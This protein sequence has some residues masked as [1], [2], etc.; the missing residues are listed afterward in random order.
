MRKIWDIPGGIHPPENK[1]QSLRSAIAAVPLPERLILPLN[2][3]A[4]APAKP[5]ISVGDRVLKGQLLAE[6]AGFISAAIHAPTSGTISAIEDHPIPHASGMSATCIML[7][8]DGRDDWCA[9]H[10]VEDYTTASPTALLGLIRDAGITGLGGAG[11]P[12]AVKLGPKQPIDTLIINGTECEPYITADDILMQERAEQII[13]GVKIIA[14]ILGNPANLLIGVEDNKPKAFDALEAAARNSGIEVIE[15]PTK[16]PSGGEKQLIQILTGKEVPSGRLPADLGIVCQNVGTTVAVYR[17]IRFGEPLI[18]R[19]TTVTGEA[20]GS[21]GN[22]EV[23]LGTPISHL[24][25]LNGFDR[26]QCGRLV[27]GGPMMGFTLTDTSVPVIKATNCILAGS[28]REFPPAPPAQACIRCG[29]CAEACPASLLPQQLFWY[30]QSQNLERLEAHNLFDCIECGACA[31]VCPSNI[32]LVQYYRAG[33]GEIRKVEAE[34]RKADHARLRFEFHKERLEKAEAE[35]TAKRE[36]RRLAA[37]AAQARASAVG[38]ATA[39]DNTATQ[40]RVTQTTAE[41]PAPTSS[42]DDMIQAAMARA[43]A[44][45]TAISPEEQQA[46]IERS[47]ETAKN[48]VQVAEAKLAE[49][50]SGQFEPEQLDKLRAKVEDARLKL[51]EAER[52]LVELVTVP[53]SSVNATVTAKVEAS[54]RQQL[55]KSISLLQERMA[56]TEGKIAEATDDAV[57]A[58]LRTGLEKQ[59]EKLAQAQQELAQLGDSADD[60]P[61][62]DQPVLDAAAAAIARAQAKAEAMAALSP[63]EKLDATLE[64]FDQRIAKAQEKLEK[65]EAE[66]SEHVDTLRSALEKLQS[67]RAETAQQRQELNN[68]QLNDQPGGQ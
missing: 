22:F 10:G 14:H 16:Y 39:T 61:V 18:S 33:K 62:A 57:I 25:Q 31:Y 50:A 52:K 40:T 32:P 42:V 13:A 66:N 15:F 24:L 55:Q 38:E 30:A 65:A 1:Q 11:F 56:T 27:M 58:A 54:P 43:A 7:V 64:S 48:R 59:R 12:S 5:V 60:Q 68:Q 46:K 20:C 8:P 26:K 63:L 45:Q 17:A 29:L 36:T 34:K 49:T 19:V 21:N 53:A 28:R 6:P 35:K 51:A 2:Q 4:G 67:K 3:H 23:L 44:R 37:E 41:L 47:I 9:H